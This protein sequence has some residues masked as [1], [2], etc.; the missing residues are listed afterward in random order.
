MYEIGRLGFKPNR[1]AEKNSDTEH[2]PLHPNCSVHFAV[3]I[4]QRLGI[5]RGNNNDGGSIVYVS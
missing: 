3:S 2:P 1:L 4:I 5:E